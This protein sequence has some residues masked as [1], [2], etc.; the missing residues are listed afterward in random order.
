M[1]FNRVALPVSNPLLLEA[2]EGPVRAGLL[3]AVLADLLEPVLA[4]LLEPV[5][6]DLPEADLVALGAPR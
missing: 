5:L 3:E 4:D 2:A 1:A 6:A